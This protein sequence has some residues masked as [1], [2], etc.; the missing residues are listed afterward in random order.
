MAPEAGLGVLDRDLL[1]VEINPADE[2]FIRRE[3]IGLNLKMLVIG[4]DER[5]NLGGRE[6]V[7]GNGLRVD[8][9]NPRRASRPQCPMTGR[10]ARTGAAFVSGAGS[11][12]AFRRGN[13]AGESFSIVRS[14]A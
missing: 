3:W 10:G 2:L 8:F 13:G 1:F 4:F 11:G 6:A 9:D 5:V 7:A 14:A 12:S